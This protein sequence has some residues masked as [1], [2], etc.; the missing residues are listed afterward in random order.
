MRRNVQHIYWFASYN[1]NGPSTRYRVNYPLKHFREHYHI[2]SDFV[3]PCSSL[4]GIANFISVFLSVLFFRKEN[5]LIVIQKVCSNRLYAN[6][7]KVLILIHRK[8]TLYDID[9]AEYLRQKTNTLHFF[10]RKCESVSVGSRK[11]FDYCSQFNAK[12]YI[13][14]SPVAIH[15]NEKV[16]KQKKLTFGWVG[17]SGN[18]D[19]RSHP[20]SHKASL[21]KLFFIPLSEINHPIK[22][23]LIGIKNQFDITEIHSF[24]K[25]FPH[26]EV[27][28]PTNL[29]WE[30]DNW[31]YADMLKFDVG[32]SP[33]LN[34]PYNQAKSAFKTKQ[35]L[36]CG[37]PVIASDVGENKTFVKNNFNGIL[38]DNPED[39]KNAI[40]KFINMDEQEYFRFSKNCMKNAA[41]YSIDNY[42]KILM[43]KHNSR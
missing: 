33:M 12:V 11:L 34:H 27:E 20:F 21:F 5:S 2:N 14:T 32:I 24:F 37:I 43:E 15:Q 13:Q 36:S 8:N 39:F 40:D 25:C 23:I 30:N 6:A 42:C 10:L 7:L 19:K 3:F 26:I 31:L 18:G 16:E 38:C 9:D 28:I 35:Y 29:N 1:L 17:D 4:K 41:K 22:L